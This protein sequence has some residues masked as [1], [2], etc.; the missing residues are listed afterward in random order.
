[1]SCMSPIYKS[2]KNNQKKEEE[3]ELKYQ[4]SLSLTKR[5][6]MVVRQSQLVLKMLIK[7]GHRKST[8]IIKRK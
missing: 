4:Q 1:M 2:K 7:N 5:F 3:F 8:E 6:R